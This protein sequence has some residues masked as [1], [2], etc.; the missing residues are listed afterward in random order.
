MCRPLAVTALLLCAAGC[1]SDSRTLNLVRVQPAVDPACGAAV[2]GR[3]LLVTALG[4]FPRSEAT[5]A[6]PS[7]STNTRFAIDTFPAETRML[8]LVVIGSGGAVRTVGRTAELDLSSLEDGADVPIFMAPPRGFCPTGDGAGAPRIDPLVVAAGDGALVAGGVDDSGA[9]VS[10]ALWYDP[11]TGSF[12]SLGD[13]FYGDPDHGLIGAS[14]TVMP[15]GRVAI[16]G[17][18]APAYQLYDPAARAAGV[19]AF[20]TVGRAHHAAIALD[21]SHLLLAGGCGALAADGSC[22]AGSALATTTILDVD[23]GAV[24][25]GPAL[26]RPR[27]DG[28][29]IR[30]ADGRVLLIGGV[31]DG[32]AAVAD[33]ERIDPGGGQPGEVVTGATGMAGRLADGGALVAMA[34]AGAIADSAAAVVPAGGSAARGVAAA[35]APRAGPTLTG[36]DDGR[37]LVMGGQGGAGGPEALL[38]S[39]QLGRFEPVD[40]SV[41]DGSGAIERD[42][43]GAALLPDGSVLIVGGRSSTGDALGDAWIFRPDLTGPYTAEVTVTFENP[44]GADLVVVPRDP[45]RFQ[46]E[47]P[48]GGLPST[49]VLQSTGTGGGLPSEWAVVAGPR[50]A[51]LSLTLRA[52]ADGGGVA[53]I[54]G[55]V[56]PGDYTAAVLLPGQKA[57]LYRVAGGQ[58]RT[59]DTCTGEIVSAAALA[60]DG[61]LAEVTLVSRGRSLT[62]TV[63][64]TALLSCPELDPP[65]RGLVGIGAVGSGDVRV[66]SIAAAR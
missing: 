62:V 49:A 17:G 27:I 25:D 64:G 33:G 36:L 3:T 6:A 5:A 2:D 55:F 38:Y 19:K 51:D 50:F 10:E 43:H 41:D 14:A 31:N 35:P 65:A 63:D 34:P 45:S 11:G 21:D 20:L 1:G 60:P 18:A 30:E 47:P 23:S 32:G 24:E 59:E 39:P 48:G 29:A 54:V 13:L 53:A 61:D 26:A 7:L 42:R 56:G 44:D 58:A 12:A 4:D 52:R 16:A 15:D 28:I 40:A 22:A 8:E 66:S 37:M 46:R 57:R 9:P